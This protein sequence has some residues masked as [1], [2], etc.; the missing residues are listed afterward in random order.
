MQKN[1]TNKTKNFF[2]VFSLPYEI[3]HHHRGVFGEGDVGGGFALD[4]IRHVVCQHPQ[5]SHPF[6]VFIYIF[7]GVPVYLIPV[8]G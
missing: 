6:L 1:A 4:K 5:G 2:I 8:T 7:R 3:G